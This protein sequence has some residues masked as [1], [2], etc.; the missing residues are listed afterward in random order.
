MSNKIRTEVY[1]RVVL[2]KMLHKAGEAACASRN[3]RMVFTKGILLLHNAAEAALGAVADHLHAKLT[4]NL[5]L[6]DYYDLIGRADPQRKPVP[7]RTQM[8]NLNTLRNNAKHQGILPDPKSNAHFPATV[9]AL[10]EEICQ[11][12]IELDFASVS[13]K[14]LIKQK[15]AL[16]YIERAEKEIKGG[17]IEEGLISLAYAMYHICEF[18]TLPSPFSYPDTQKEEETPLQFTQPYK[19]EYTV[20]LIERGVDPYLYHRFNN[21]TP[22]IA[23]HKDTGKLFY[24]WDK[25]YGHPVNWT[26]PNAR[27]CLHFCIETALKFQREE[28][29]AYT[30]ISYSEVFEDV[31]EPANEEAIIW[32]QSSHP[33]K[34]LFPKTSELRNPVLVLKKGQSIVG[35]AQDSEDRLD[36]WLVMS[37]D[38]PSKLKEFPGF[39][40]VLKRD[41]KVTPR[42]KQTP[43]SASDLEVRKEG[44][45]DGI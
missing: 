13:L 42:K 24:W 16:G 11:T 3:D 27:F 1:E 37:E 8:R 2:A 25:S 19:T 21:L 18:V 36:E 44:E 29:E 15:E 12:H 32:N 7:Y 38:I 14:S 45:A 33:S 26:I 35:S 40:F 28:G 41:V 34:H 22:R 20:E 5:Y 10:I 31:I 6:L 39:G 4:G 30:L 23:K 43:K 9:Y 17:E